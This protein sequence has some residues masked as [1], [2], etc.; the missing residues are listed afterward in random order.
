MDASL[1][2]LTNR[3][4]A[5]HVLPDILV[6]GNQL[7]LFVESAPMIARLAADI[8]LATRRVWIET[9]IFAS[10]ATGRLIAGALIDRARAGL[11][12][13]LLYD[14]FGSQGTSQELLDEMTAAGVQLHAFHSFWYALRNISFLEILNRRD[15][16]KL[17]VLDDAAA[18]FGGMNIVDTLTPPPVAGPSKTD[19]AGGWR[20]VHVRLTGPGV[21]DVAESFERSWLRAHHEPIDRRPRDYRRVRLPR[22]TQDF[23]CFYDSGP[24]LHF[25]RAERVFTRLIGLARQ[26]VVLSMAYFLPTRRVLRTILRA[27]QRRARITILVPGVSDVPLVQRATRY[28]YRLLLS[29][30]IAIFER[31]H[32]M[33][34]SKAMVVDDRWTVIGSCNLDPRSLEINLEFVAV[35]RSAAMA[36]A[37]TNICE[38]EL[39]QSRP[40]TMAECVRYSLWQR[41]LDRL[42]YM[43]RWWL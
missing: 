19:N 35:I 33:L 9:Y 20:D 25:S 30:D 22:G 21:V 2:Q 29:R 7:H 15:H 17:Y 18:Y 42:A 41:L 14:A 23:I 32:S 16:R 43:L 38:H 39:S 36:Q 5:D 34:H 13:R 10:D 8:R 4:T 11:D 1:P 27:R 26:R 31:Q 24:G 37:V 3:P 12:V 6:A 28:L 40:V